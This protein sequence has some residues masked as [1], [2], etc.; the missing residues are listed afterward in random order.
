M[1]DKLVQFMAL[2]LF[3][4]L[5]LR[6]GAD[7]TVHDVDQITLVSLYREIEHAL[8]QYDPVRGQSKTFKHVTNTYIW[9]NTMTD[10][11]REEVAKEI[12]NEIK[13]SV[14]SYHEMGCIVLS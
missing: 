1:K 11:F 4:E 13:R 14:N 8:S 10:N 6:F 3:A 2:R 7:I 5:F 12:L 9:W